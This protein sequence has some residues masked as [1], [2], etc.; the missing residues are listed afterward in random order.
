MSTSPAG[1]LDMSPL[2]PPP[3]PPSASP[4]PILYVMLF[5]MVRR[6]VLG[7]SAAKVKGSACVYVSAY[8]CLNMCSSCVLYTSV[9]LHQVILCVCVC[10]NMCFSCVLYTSVSILQVI[11]CVCVGLVVIPYFKIN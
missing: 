1:D 10:L 3:P 6:L 4:T 2:P 8:L 5:C 7:L 9:S 11:V